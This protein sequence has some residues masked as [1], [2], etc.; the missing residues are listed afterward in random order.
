MGVAGEVLSQGSPSK[1]RENI[2]VDENARSDL[3]TCLNR[4]VAEAAERLAKAVEKARPS[5]LAEFYSKLFPEK[6]SPTPPIASVLAQHVRSELEP[7]E[8][9]DLWN[10]VFPEDRHVWYNEE[11]NAIPRSTEDV[12]PAAR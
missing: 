9:V 1:E 3:A 2:T 10:V 11:T 4:L 5:D 8:I 7:E 6:P 12:T